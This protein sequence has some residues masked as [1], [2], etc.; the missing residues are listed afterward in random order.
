[1]FKFISKAML[2]MVMDKNAREK[3]G[4]RKAPAK[5]A[6]SQ[7]NTAA[8]KNTA[9]QK[10]TAAQK[11][12]RAP[13]PEAE[14]PILAKRPNAER[15]IKKILAGTTKAEKTEAFQKLLSGKLAKAKPGSAKA[16]PSAAGK[17]SRGDAKSREKLIATALAVQ[18]A[19]AHLL[20]GVNDKM[21]EKI[22]R[23]ATAKMG[24]D[25]PTKH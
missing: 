20:D 22:R 3:L 8:K 7:K 6:S 1:M 18:R 12:N 2:S 23:L 9:T 21:R 24:D 16:S 11:K 13:L 17:G 4:K 14:T 10:N 5:K 15:A 25:G 19:Q